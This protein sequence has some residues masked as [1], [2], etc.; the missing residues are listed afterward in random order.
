MSIL[1]ALFFFPFLSAIG[2]LD[3]PVDNLNLSNCGFYGTSI[4]LILKAL[5]HFSDDLVPIS[6]I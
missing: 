1:K 4:D 2:S 3:P 6:T 5:Y